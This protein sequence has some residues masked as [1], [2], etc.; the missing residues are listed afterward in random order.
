MYLPGLQS[1]IWYK[2]QLPQRIAS[3]VKAPFH[4]TMAGHN[5][6]GDRD[7]QTTCPT[8]PRLHDPIECTFSVAVHALRGMQLSNINTYQT[9]AAQLNVPSQML[10]RILHSLVTYLTR[11]RNISRVVTSCAS[12]C[13]SRAS[14]SISRRHK[15]QPSVAA[16]IQLP[17]LLTFVKQTNLVPLCLTT[18]TNLSTLASSVKSRTDVIFHNFQWIYCVNLQKHTD[19]VSWKSTVRGDN[20]I[21]KNMLASRK[22]HGRSHFICWY[23]FWIKC[24]LADFNPRA[25]RIG[26]GGLYLIWDK[27]SCSCL[28]L[29]S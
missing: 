6:F 18:E 9:R 23:R 27:P 25:K 26:L 5:S 15:S 13:A 8:V 16:M 12:L 10:Y 2:W 11:A 29:K 22:L 28:V 19:G 20:A 1:L 14:L 17:S 7:I 24:K 3:S 4:Y 21:S